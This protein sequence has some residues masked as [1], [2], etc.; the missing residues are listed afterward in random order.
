[1]KREA[2]RHPKMYDLAARLSCGRPAAI[3][4]LQLML[5]YAA[6]TAPQGNIGKWPNAVIASACEWPGDP[7]DFMR[8]M[9]G[10]GWVDPCPTYRLVIHDLADHAERWWHLKLQKKGISF[11]V[12]TVDGPIDRT[13][14][15]S[16]LLCS[17]LPTP[18]QT[19]TAPL[20]AK[21][22]AAEVSIPASLDLPPFPAAWSDWLAYRL[23][24]RLSTRGRT[25]ALQLDSLAPLG[26]A[27]AAECVKLSIRNGWQGLFP[28]KATAA[29]PPKRQ[30]PTIPKAKVTR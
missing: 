11:V 25:M 21:P 15:A 3:G 4:Y 29:G 13:T 23:E 27:A 10:A 5:D 22:D 9:M 24:R 26:P 20:L 18:S 1:V 2:Y 14:E 7:N 28:E 17:S 16:I 8:G 12:A 6:D 30:P 19:P